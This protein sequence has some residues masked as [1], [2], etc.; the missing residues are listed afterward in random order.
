MNWF[1]SPAVGT[2]IG[3]LGILI[4]AGVSYYFYRKSLRFK[5]LIWSVATTTLLD[6]K[7]SNIK[8]LEIVYKGSKITSLYTSRLVIYNS[9]TDSISYSD[10]SERDT[11]AI[12]LEWSINTLQITQ[13]ND[14]Y[15]FRQRVSA[16]HM[17]HTN[18]YRL[19]FEYIKPKEGVVLDVLHTGR[20]IVDV[21]SGGVAPRDLESTDI[22]LI[23]DLKNGRIIHT[24]RRSLESLVLSDPSAVTTEN[25]QEH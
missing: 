16:T 18:A 5:E 1:D 3:V 6:D 22:A 20:Y 13:L 25:V 7:L 23:G 10:V 15:N 9:G 8:D 4:G 19:T 21:P 17:P 24:T 12:G 2:I 14:G 11:L